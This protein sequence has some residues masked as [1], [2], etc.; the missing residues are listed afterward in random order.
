MIEAKSEPKQEEREAA[1]WFTRMLNT[2]IENEA[3]AAFAVWRQNPDNLAAYNR[4]EDISRLALSLQDDPDLRAVAHAA[5]NRRTPPPAW[6]RN[7]FTGSRQ[8]WAVG[9]AIGGLVAASAVVWRMTAPTYETTVGRQIVAQLPDGS[10][11]RLNTD[12]ALNVRFENGVRRVELARGQAFFDVAHDAAHPFIVVAGDTEVRAIGTRFDVRRED[13]GAKVILA[14]GK[15]AVTERG[16][17]SSAWTLVPGQTVTT[18]KAIAPQVLSV[19]DITVATGWTDGR[20]KFR[21]TPLDEAVEEVNRYSRDKIIL[22]ADV[23][24][25]TRVNG[26]FAIGKPSDF[27]TAM[28]T[29]YGLKSERRLGGDIEL[30]GGAD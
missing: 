28:T 22:G 5:R 4:M 8:R 14:E 1:E 17:R 2:S 26:D 6:Y 25:D 24:T 10:R 9:I 3:L 7:I 20:L 29:L 21:A 12:T 19:T 13:G 30:R 16:A 15:V 18:G 23:P 11:V 27:I